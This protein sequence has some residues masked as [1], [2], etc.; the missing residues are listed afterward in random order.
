MKL[1]TNCGELEKPYEITLPEGK[2]FM[3]SGWS[4]ERRQVRWV[5]VDTGESVGSMCISPGMSVAQA[6]IK[7]GTPRTYRLEG[8]RLCFDWVRE[9]LFYLGLTPSAAPRRSASYT[10]MEL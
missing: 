2:V 4:Q 7:W 3:L 6:V 5:C 10:V 8:D 1:Y 9:L